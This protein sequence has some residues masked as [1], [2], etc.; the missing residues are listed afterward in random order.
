[1]VVKTPRYDIGPDELAEVEEEI[2]HESSM[3][4]RLNHPNIIKYY[5]TGRV[6]LKDGASHV[7]VAVRYLD[8]TFRWRWGNCDTRRE[9]SKQTHTFVALP[10]LRHFS[11]DERRV[12]G[13][14]R[15]ATYGGCLRDRLSPCALV[16]APRWSPFGPPPH[17]SRPDS[18]WRSS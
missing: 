13:W 3:L 14:E 12:S 2:E 8:G 6:P 4:Q 11:R 9:P 18:S 17:L 16:V 7:F 15:L 10:A 5:G 1:M